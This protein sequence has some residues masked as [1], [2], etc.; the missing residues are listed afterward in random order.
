MTDLPKRSDDIYKEIE[1]FKDYELTQCVAYEMAIRN[2]YAK[3]LLFYYELHLNQYNIDINLGISNIENRT[4]NDDLKN[5]SLF[6][7]EELEELYLEPISLQNFFY[8]KKNKE[9]KENKLN[10]TTISK[11]YQYPKHGAGWIDETKSESREVFI[12]KTSEYKKDDS[13]HIHDISNHISLILSRPKLISDNS[14]NATINLNLSLPLIELTAYLKEIKLNYEKDT[15]IIKTPLELLGNELQN[16]N[17]SKLPKKPK[18]KL[19]ADLFFVYD[20]VKARLSEKE[21]NN[22]QIIEQYEKDKQNISNNQGLSTSDKRIQKAELLIEF[23]ENKDNTKQEDI[24][25]DDELLKQLDIKS[26]SISKYYTLMKN[27][28]DKLKYKELVTGVS[29]NQNVK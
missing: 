26:N 15:S 13:Y 25:Q 4:L 17:N 19:W 5:D 8:Q 3:E 6:L 7:E 24:Y 20:Y 27:Y 23:E 18:A 16:A 12:S 22:K 29:I 21:N 1:S 10:I 11:E 28:I 9:N 2:D 14:K